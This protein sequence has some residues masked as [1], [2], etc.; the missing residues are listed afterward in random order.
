MRQNHCL[1]RSIGKFEEFLGDKTSRPDFR[2][3]DVRV[4]VAKQIA[5]LHTGGK[6]PL[7]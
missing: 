5:A 6:I 3:E 4:S 2:Y 1:T 7:A